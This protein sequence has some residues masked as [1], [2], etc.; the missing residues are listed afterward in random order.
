MN[1]EAFWEN[2]F[3][4]NDA[5]VRAAAATL[6]AEE[7]ASV[8]GFLRRLQVD[9][10]RIEEQRRAAVFALGILAPH[11]PG[12]ALLPEGALAFAKDLARQTGQKL[13]THF[14][15][16]HSS[17]KRDGTLVTEADLESDRLITDAI[18]AR[19]PEHQVLSEERDKVYDGREWAWIIDP[20]DGTTNFA[21][22]FPCWG[23]LIALLHHG[24]PVLGVAEFPVLNEHYHAVAGGGAWLNDQPVRAAVRALGPDGQPTID[25]SDLLSTCSRTLKHGRVNLPSKLRVSGSSGY[26]LALLGGG[27]LIG[28]LQRRVYVWDVAAMWLLAEEAGAMLRT[29]PAVALF[30]IPAG[31]DCANQPFSMAGAVSPEMLERIIGS[32]IP[33]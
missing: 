20:I 15:S 32:L 31:F 22:G 8:I 28:T 33:G 10:E 27:V 14:G 3:S 12:Q 6:D 23:V 29:D 30:P 24:Q 7:R 16:S 26:D 13:H 5:Q 19:Y 25:G 2:I 9:P 17:V 4:E 18:H 1:I 11:V 21:H